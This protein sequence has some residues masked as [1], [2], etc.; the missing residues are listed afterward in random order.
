MGTKTISVTEAAY[1]RLAQEKRRGESF[2]DVILRLTQRR[3][4]RDLA[5]T[6]TSEEAEALSEAIAKNREERLRRRANR[7]D[8]EEDE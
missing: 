3:S 8:L 1:Q 5:E 4:L 6:V 2:T 7:L